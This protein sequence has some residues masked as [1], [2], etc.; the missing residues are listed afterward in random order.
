MTRSGLVAVAALVAGCAAQSP[1]VAT[2]DHD[3]QVQACAEAVAAHVGKGVDAV[4]A[5]WTG[6]TAES[7][8]VVTVRDQQGTAGERVHTCEV[9]AVGQVR[10]ILH[11]GA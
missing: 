8:G 10:A 1:Q 9:D 11:P 3:L 6:D 2:T 7:L 5:S 4:T